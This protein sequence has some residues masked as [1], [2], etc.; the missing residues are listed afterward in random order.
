MDTYAFHAL[1][2]SDLLKLQAMQ[3]KMVKKWKAFI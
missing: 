1:S 2:Y 3:I